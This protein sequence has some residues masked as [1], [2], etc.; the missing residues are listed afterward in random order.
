MKKAPK[1]VIIGYAGG[2]TLEEEFLEDITAKGVNLSK[3]EKKIDLI[4]GMLCQS[5]AQVQ[6]VLDFMQEAAMIITS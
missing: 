6:I 4:K 1:E 5:K 3:V 2:T